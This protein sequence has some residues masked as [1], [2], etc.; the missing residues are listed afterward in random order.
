MKKLKLYKKG[1]LKASFFLNIFLLALFSLFALS[2]TSCKS[3][4]LQ[5][6]YVDPLELLDNDS[7]F[8]LSIPYS[9]DPALMT[10]II[11]SN[12]S[13]IGQENAENAAKRVGVVYAGFLKSRKSME[14]QLAGNVDFPKMIQGKVFTR[15]NGWL[16]STM[17]I[18]LK[19]ENPVKYSIWSQN[20]LDISL[21]SDKIILLGRDTKGMLER[22]HSKYFD[23]NLESD[24]KLIAPVKEYLSYSS[25]DKPAEIKFYATRP[26]SFLTMLT[27]ANLTLKL[28]Y[29]R[30]SMRLDPK[31]D[32]QYLMDL[33]FDFKDSRTVPAA[34]GVLSVAFGLTDSDVTQETP[35]H[36]TISNIKINK[37]Q[38]YKLLSL[39]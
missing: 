18:K 12:V 10:R 31:L 14:V 4:A 9:A 8:F 11:E 1:A 21:P 29:V 5:E 23:I 22:Y 20:D 15:K 25:S 39:I 35:W 16:E 37:E 3:S 24:K 38:L 34:R 19:D 26:Q 17:D 36:L 2:F 6:I 28:L 32:K 7:S 33:E 13:S 27:G 30:G